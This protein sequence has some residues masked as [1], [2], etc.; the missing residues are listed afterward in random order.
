MEKLKYRTIWL[1]IGYLMVL[2]VIYSSLT[3]NPVDIGVTNSDKFLHI[4]GYFGLMAWFIQIYQQKLVRFFLAIAF[5]C[6]GVSLEFL[7][8]MGGVRYFEVNDMIANASGVLLA[9][10]LVVTPLS[11]S[12]H[13][14][15][16][17]V[18]KV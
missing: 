11:R 17:C 3:P 15:E 7:Q 16:E 8:G 2:F 5:I 12:L 10:L 1:A 6:M 14:F 13:W 4:I 9:S 18:L